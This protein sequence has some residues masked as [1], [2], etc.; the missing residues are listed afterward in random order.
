MNREQ[1]MEAIRQLAH[2]QGSYS[3]FYR[4]LCEMRDNEPERFDR[5]MTMLEEK[6][7]KDTV[8]LVMYL[9]S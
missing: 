2:S 7:F 5:A 4:D 8:D 6:N 3:R 1:I 9:E